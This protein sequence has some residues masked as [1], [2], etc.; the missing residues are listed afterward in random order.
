MPGKKYNSCNYAYTLVILTSPFETWCSIV[1]STGK[2]F[3]GYLQQLLP[4][5]VA[6]RVVANGWQNG[7]SINTP[8]ALPKLGSHSARGTAFKVTGL[9]S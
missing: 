5:S 4:F 3:L 1:I 9:T 8:I 2:Y 7:N 6:K